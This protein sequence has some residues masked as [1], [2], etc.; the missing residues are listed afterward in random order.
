MRSIYYQNS[1][2][3]FVLLLI[4]LIIGGLSLYYTN[5]MVH[6]VRKQERKNM[7]LWANATKALSLS[8]EFDASLEVLV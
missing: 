2:W 3:K 7:E 6:S 1:R 4:A 5:R 8:G